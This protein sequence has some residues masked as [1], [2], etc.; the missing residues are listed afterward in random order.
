FRIK[1]EIIFF[2][3]SRRRH[4]RWPH[5]WSSDVC[6]SDLAASQHLVLPEIVSDAPAFPQSLQLSAEAFQCTLQRGFKSCGVSN[7]SLCEVRSEERRV[8]KECRSRWWR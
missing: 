3:S 8:G 6:S 4:T 1:S 5:D 2:F 7:T